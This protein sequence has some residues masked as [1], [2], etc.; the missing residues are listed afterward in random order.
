MAYSTNTNLYAAKVYAENPLALWPI[1]DDF[2]FISQISESDKDISN[3]TFDNGN[4][5]SVAS[6]SV[7]SRVPFPNEALSG[8]SRN[9]GSNYVTYAIPSSGIDTNNLDSNKDTI[10]FNANVWK[11]SSLVNG[12]RIGFQYTSGSV[13]VTDT[14]DF[15]ALSTSSGWQKISHTFNYPENTTIYPYLEIDFIEGG[16]DN[17]Y[18]IFVNALSVGQWSEK[19]HSETTGIIPLNLPSSVEFYDLLPTPSGSIQ[20]STID[21]YGLTTADDGYYLIDN[22]RMLAVNNGLPMIFGAANITN[23]YPPITPNMPSIVIPGKGFL[24]R[25][26]QYSQL[27]AEFWLRIYNESQTPKRIFGPL[28]SKDGLYVEE[29]FLTLRVGKYSKSYFI[30]KWYRPMLIDIRY[31]PTDVSILINGLNVMNMDIVA[32][33]LTLP[34]VNQDWLGFYSYEETQPFEIDCIAVYPYFVSDQLAKRRF[35]YGQGVESPDIVSSNFGGDSA[36]IDFS[37]SK[38]SSDFEFPTRV[39]WGAGSFSNLETNSQQLTFPTYDLPEIKLFGDDLSIF[40]LISE[41][42]KWIEVAEQPWSYWAENADWERVSSISPGDILKDSFSIQ[43]TDPYPFISMRPNDDYEEIYPTI[44]FD[45]INKI[46]NPVSSIFGVFQTSA[47]IQAG[48]QTIVYMRNKLTQEYFEIY[49]NS[50]SIFY[51]FNETVLN[52]ETVSASSTF[53]A[54]IDIDKISSRFRRIVERFFAVPQNISLNLGGYESNTFLGKIYSFTFNNRLFTDKDLSSYY[55]VLGFAK[56]SAS[57]NPALISNN[58]YIMKYVGNYTLLPL[59]TSSTIQ[60]DIGC[61]GYWESSIPLSVLG[62]NTISSDGQVFYDLDMIQFNID[63][64]SPVVVQ[65]GPPH[66]E[67]DTRLKSYITLQDFRR[68]GSIPYTNWTQTENISPNRVIDFD[69][70]IDV[71]QTKYEVVDGTVIFPPKQLV[72]FADYYLVVHLEMTTRGINTMP[73][74]L[75]RMAMSSLAFDESGFYSIGTKT[76]RDIFPFTRY[77]NNYAPKEKNPFTIYKGSTP[78]LYLTDDSGISVLDYPTTSTAR[79]LTLPINQLKASEFSLGG[80]QLWTFY[81]EKEVFDE[82][83]TIASINTPDIKLDFVLIPEAN[84]KRARMTIF[85]NTTGIEFKDAQF[86]QNGNLVDNPYIQ[87]MEWASIVVSLGNSININGISGQ[88]ELY[89][90]MLFNNIAFL[91]KQTDVF[92]TTTETRNWSELLSDPIIGPLSWGF[93]TAYNWSQVANYNTTQLFSIN[94][95]E[96]FNSYLGL[97]KAVIVDDTSIVLNS[98]SVQKFMNI[99]WS[100]FNGKPV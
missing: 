9:S 55:N 49:Q 38:Y 98:E 48:K 33:D 95:I 27:T 3:W 99:R 47:S 52:T 10:C 19:F 80:I 25:T 89:H 74:K 96:I 13:V 62:K 86:Y 17:E 70:T 41:P 39:A 5:A 15:V 32:D 43:G 7:V 61:A 75:Q 77:S 63:F 34:S 45:N 42:R 37:F 8:F 31:T 1:D 71:I 26:G 65:Q 4:S 53:I 20:Y 97:A 6:A 40:T 72:N 29:E 76:G 30:G 22:K 14:T 68:A 91:E 23:L 16:S 12:Y 92:A 90:G 28:S 93:W 50:S 94:G 36:F 83:I 81:K 51:A 84:G 56:T 85:N 44:F 73:V 24:N 59:R 67:D 100:Q 11:I 35:V 2:S 69:N 57:V 60:L 54:G 58:E 21:S 82:N 78:Y 79:G 87:P 88:F 46:T 66:S 64:P 18:S